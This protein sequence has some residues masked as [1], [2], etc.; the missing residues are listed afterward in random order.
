[1]ETHC[2]VTLFL[3]RQTLD[4][5]DE[6][7]HAVHVYPNKPTPCARSAFPQL[8][9]G[10]LFPVRGMQPWLCSRGARA[11]AGA[12]RRLTDSEFAAQERIS[13]LPRAP[14]QLKYPSAS[15]TLTFIWPLL[16]EGI[17]I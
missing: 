10:Q 5:S 9:H 8:R 7:L 2:F 16:S 14:S 4:L 17:K 15:H 1:M 11:G 12:R 3:A 13:R 6:F